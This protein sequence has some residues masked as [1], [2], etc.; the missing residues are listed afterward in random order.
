MSH[1]AL[2]PSQPPLVTQL[3]GLA[4]DS[5]KLKWVPMVGP[6]KMGGNLVMCEY[7]DLQLVYFI[8][9]L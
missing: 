9:S 6:E 7:S 3:T 8:I 2:L 4:P 1:N 5:L